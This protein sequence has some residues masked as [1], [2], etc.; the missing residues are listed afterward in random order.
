MGRLTTICIGTSRLRWPSPPHSLNACTDRGGE[1]ENGDGGGEERPPGPP[2]R[3]GGAAGDRLSSI[4]GGKHPRRPTPVVDGR[5]GE[6][7]VP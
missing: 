6:G 4:S 5:G 7:V 3:A 2:P 1:E